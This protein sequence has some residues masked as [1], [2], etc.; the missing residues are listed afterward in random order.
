MTFH[1][2]RYKITA[3]KTTVMFF[4]PQ[5]QLIFELCCLDGSEKKPARSRAE[6]KYHNLD[7][8]RCDFVLVFMVIVWLWLCACKE[9]LGKIGLLLEWGSS[10]LGTSNVPFFPASLLCG[11]HFSLR[12]CCH[13]SRVDVNI[14]QFYSFFKC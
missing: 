14:F 9:G 2:S 4:S 5:E 12:C 10:Q 3:L 1:K 8:R 11:F 7:I 6:K 13:V